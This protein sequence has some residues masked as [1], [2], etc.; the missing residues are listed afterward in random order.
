MPISE[1]QLAANKANAQKSTGPRSRMGRSNSSRNAMKHGLLANA[2]LIDGESRESFDELLCALRH[3]YQ[4]VTETDYALIQKAA[5]YQWRLL[6]SW[7]LDSAAITYEMRR[8]A[9]ANADQNTPTRA[10]LAMRSL[11]QNSRQ[12]EL[13]SRYEHRFDV[14]HHRAL[15]DLRRRKEAREKAVPNKAPLSK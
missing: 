3:E 10:M 15:Q 4:P 8:Q 13:M 6:R 1:K 7:T 14:Q 5:V 9:D 11:C 12:P 2:I